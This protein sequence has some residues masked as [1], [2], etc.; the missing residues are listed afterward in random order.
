M[1]GGGCSITGAHTSHTFDRF[2]AGEQQ[3]V[4]ERHVVFSPFNFHI[5][6]VANAHT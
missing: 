1:R 6:D 4:L 5:E 2:G 3:P